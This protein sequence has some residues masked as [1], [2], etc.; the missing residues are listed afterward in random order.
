MGSQAG[1]WEPAKNIA[2]SFCFLEVFRLH[3]MPGQQSIKLGAV[4]FGQLGSLSHTA[5]GHLQQADQIIPFELV[6]GILQ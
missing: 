4:A 1:A 2:R 6:P 3:A 5:P